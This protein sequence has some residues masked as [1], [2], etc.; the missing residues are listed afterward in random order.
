[1]KFILPSKIP[2]F[3]FQFQLLASQDYWTNFKNSPLTIEYADCSVNF[4]QA[5]SHGKWNDYCPVGSIEF[6]GCHGISTPPRNIPPQLKEYA[7][8]T[9]CTARSEMMNTA[10]RWHVKSS[11]KIKHPDNGVY[12]GIDEIPFEDGRFQAVEFIDEGFLSEWRVFVLDGNIVDVQNYAGDLWTLPNRDAVEHMVYKF[13]HT[14]GANAPPAYTL[15]VGVIPDGRTC[16][17][18]VHDFYSCGTYNFNDHYRLPL[19]L[20][21]WWR[22]HV[23]SNNETKIALKPAI[24]KDDRLF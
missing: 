11:D 4:E 23:F 1:M 15:D 13:E 12:A 18:E 9:V 5:Y 24:S 7:C 16:I 2:Q 19:M 6:C 20:W 8:G 3:D 22:W 21:S 14:P 17:V 10:R